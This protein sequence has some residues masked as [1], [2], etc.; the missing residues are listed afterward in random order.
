LVYTDALDII[1][2]HPR[3]GA[4]VVHIPT[5]TIIYIYA[6]GTKETRTIMRA[7]IVAIYTALTTLSTHE[8]IGI[9]T[10]FLS[11]LQAIRHHHTN[12]G[13]IMK[14]DEICYNT[15]KTRSA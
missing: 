12:P 15:R 10:D 7:E 6:A 4:A 14:L 8:W 2:G 3:F 11:S 9:F 5:T 13:T 1:T